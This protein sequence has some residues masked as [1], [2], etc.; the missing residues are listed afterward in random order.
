MPKFTEEEDMIV[1]EHLSTFYSY[2]DNINI[3]NEGVDESLCPET[4]W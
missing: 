4:L 2:V 1:E 3:E